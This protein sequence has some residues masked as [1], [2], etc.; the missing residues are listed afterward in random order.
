MNRTTLMPSLCCF[1]TL[2]IKT[3]DEN[4]P[5]QS[6]AGSAEV[7][8]DP[9]KVTYRMLLKNELLGAG[10]DQMQVKKALALW[11]QSYT[12]LLPLSFLWRPVG[13]PP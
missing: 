11:W 4:E 3:V 13:D 8:D 10:V 5:S 6:A 2:S 1:H 9:G 12:C 7:R